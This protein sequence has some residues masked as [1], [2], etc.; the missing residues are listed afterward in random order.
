MFVCVI[1]FE[2]MKTGDCNQLF[3]AILI[4]FFQIYFLGVDR[5]NK[6]CVSVHILVVQYIPNRMIAVSPPS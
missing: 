6:K 4:A 5:Q 2:L 1:T 3:T